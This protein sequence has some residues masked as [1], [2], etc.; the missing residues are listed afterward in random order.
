MQ[1]SSLVVDHRSASLFRKFRV[2]RHGI[3]ARSFRRFIH[4]QSLLRCA[5]VR[6][7]LSKE[8]C[9]PRVVAS[10]RLARWPTARDPPALIAFLINTNKW[11]FLIRKKDTTVRT[12]KL[13]SFKTFSPNAPYNFLESFVVRSTWTR[14]Q[15][16]VV[17]GV[18][19]LA[20]PWILKLSWNLI[21]SGK[22]EFLHWFGIFDLF[23]F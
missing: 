23:S 20:Y 5:V 9:V 12:I 14:A 3:M 13:L 10:R 21:Y 22:L 4:G 15:S 1:V 2:P 18:S 8:K 16:V 17:Y 11:T 19:N 6:K 7:L